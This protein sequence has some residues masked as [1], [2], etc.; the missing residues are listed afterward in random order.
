MSLRIRTALA[1]LLA[2][3]LIAAP[4]LA[5]RFGRRGP[6]PAP[7]PLH[8]QFVGPASGG[9][10]AW[11]AGVPGDTAVWYLGSA[12]GGV[13]KSIDGGHSFGPVFDNEPVQA[14]GALAVAPSDHN[15]V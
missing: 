12:S 6:P 15:V 14:I 7:P 8:F 10:I 11:L 13:W 9:R 4:S 3:P 5:Q 2:L 1:G